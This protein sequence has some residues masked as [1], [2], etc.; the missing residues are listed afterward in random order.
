MKAMVRSEVQKVRQTKMPSSRANSGHRTH[1]TGRASRIGKAMSRNHVAKLQAMHME[2]PRRTLKTGDRRTSHDKLKPFFRQT[3]KIHKTANKFAQERRDGRY[4]KRVG[5]RVVK[6]LRRMQIPIK[7]IKPAKKDLKKVIKLSKKANAKMKRTL[8]GR[9]DARKKALLRKMKISKAVM[10]R[11]KK[12]VKSAAKSG[13]NSALKKANREVTAAKHVAN[14]VKLDKLAIEKKK[15]KTRLK[16][17]NHTVLRRQRRVKK[18]ARA[19]AKALRRKK[20]SLLIKAKERVVKGQE[21]KAR[22]QARA[23]RRKTRKIKRS[24][25]RIRKRVKYLGKHEKR[26]HWRFVKAKRAVRK[27]GRAALKTKD[28]VR[29]AARRVNVA[30]KVATLADERYREAGHHMKRK[31][32]EA[33]RLVKTSKKVAKAL[34]EAEKDEQDALERST[35]KRI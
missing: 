20:K 4:V 22:Y 21:Q 19:T 13:S 27:D 24:L 23:L 9:R 8:V 16:K 35:S 34:Q 31:R 25:K 6:S 2:T 32:K 33:S 18:A 17:V 26:A 10:K 28:L 11:A 14:Q 29:R 1:V 30:I 3:S 5:H 7:S 15:L 12:S